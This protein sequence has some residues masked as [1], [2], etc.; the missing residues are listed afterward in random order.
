VQEQQLPSRRRSFDERPA[1]VARV[2]DQIDLLVGEIVE[3]RCSDVARGEREC[4]QEVPRAELQASLPCRAQKHEEGHHR[5]NAVAQH[6]EIEAR[7]L[8]HFG[9]TTLSGQI[10]VSTRT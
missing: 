4:S 9:V 7:Q 8:R 5:S 1:C 10:D 3:S 2:I 6:H